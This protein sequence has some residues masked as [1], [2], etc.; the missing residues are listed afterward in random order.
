M[1]S[2]PWS[3]S[4]LPEQAVAS[5]LDTWSHM[6]RTVGRRTLAVSPLARKTSRIGITSSNTG[7][8]EST[9]RMPTS[10]VENFSHER[11]SSIFNLPLRGEMTMHLHILKL[12]CHRPAASHCSLSCVTQRH[13]VGSGMCYVD[14]NDS[15]TSKLI[16]E[17]SPS[18]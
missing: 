2:P 6:T 7:P 14:R 3:L 16:S 10:P 15:G 18:F 12:K 17:G 11:P 5:T 1:K 13:V 8:P 9:L 4:S